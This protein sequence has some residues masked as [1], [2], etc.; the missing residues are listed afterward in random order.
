MKQPL[1]EGFLERL[2]FF[3]KNDICPFKQKAASWKPG[4]IKPKSKPQNNG[5]VLKIQLPDRSEIGIDHIKF[6]VLPKPMLVFG[7]K[8]KPLPIKACGCLQAKVVFFNKS[9]AGLIF[10]ACVLENFGGFFQTQGKIGRNRNAHFLPKKQKLG[11]RRDGQIIEPVAQS[12]GLEINNIAVGIKS[13]HGAIWF[14]V[15]SFALEMDAERK[16]QPFFGQK[17][18]R[19]PSLETKIGL[20]AEVVAF[21]DA[22]GERLF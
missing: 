4:S 11:P 9:V 18:K 16:N 17:T 12:V 20:V 7:Q 19:K 21:V 15:K 10:P 6:F 3:K 1:Q 22:V 14:L 8:G 5:P 13:G 2:F